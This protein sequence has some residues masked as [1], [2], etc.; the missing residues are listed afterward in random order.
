GLVLNMRDI[1]ERK[2]LEARLTHQAFHDPLTGLANRALFAN[3][4]EHALASS[5]RRGLPIGVLFLD[6]DNFKRV[7]D[8]FGHEAGGA[9]LVEVAN[10][11]RTC[12]R[13]G[14][15][16]ARFGGDEFAV[17][18][19]ELTSRDEAL[20]VA[21]RILDVLRPAIVVNSAELETSASV[22]LAMSGGDV[23]T[24]GE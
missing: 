18:L 1:S 5:A 22:G 6:L 13:A 21:R 24:A 17:L 12:L 20:S 4:V 8:S 2:R 16:P 10:R 3:R 23:G 9:G 11:L 19:E 15:T 14:D 7:N